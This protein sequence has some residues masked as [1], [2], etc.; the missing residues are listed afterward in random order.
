[1]DSPSIV[2]HW[3][4]QTLNLTWAWLFF[5]PFI[6]FPWNILRRRTIS[7]YVCQGNLIFVTFRYDQT[8]T[9]IPKSWGATLCIGCVPLLR[10]VNTQDQCKYVCIDRKQ[11]WDFLCTLCVIFSGNIW[12]R[13]EGNVNKI[14]LVKLESA[15]RKKLP[16][17]TSHSPSS[18]FIVRTLSQKL[19]S[20]QEE[21]LS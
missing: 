2:E 14:R 13:E 8:F 10:G 19:I 12:E 6:F 18:S 11:H 17:S 15:G 16:L 3:T 21:S 9:R 1:M 20:C 5:A 4:R 7:I